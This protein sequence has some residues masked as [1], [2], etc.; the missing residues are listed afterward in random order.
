MTFTKRAALFTVVAVLF[1]GCASWFQQRVEQRDAKIEA[2]EQER[3]AAETP[4]EEER[5]DEAI[6]DEREDREKSLDGAL[7][8]QKNKQALLMAL[9]S[10]GVGG[11]KVAAGLAAKGV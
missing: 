5:I 1:T 8:E 11:L 9:I 3:A 7:E 4:A 2:L 10:M 6:A